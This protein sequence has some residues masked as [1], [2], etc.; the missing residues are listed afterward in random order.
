MAMTSTHSQDGRAR[1]LAS[2]LARRLATQAGIDLAR[3]DGSGP[4]GRIIK[5]DI[6]AALGSGNGSGGAK[7]Q[8]LATQP[9]PAP[10]VVPAM[11]DDKILALYDK[12]TYEIVPA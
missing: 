4:H 9:Q 3:L 7:G 10:A 2:P 11:S 5:R 6:E 8:A 12:G 1:I